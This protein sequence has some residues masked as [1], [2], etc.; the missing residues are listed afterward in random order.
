MINLFPHLKE[1]GTNRIYRSTFILEVHFVWK[2][3]LIDA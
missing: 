3:V 1:I 2:Q